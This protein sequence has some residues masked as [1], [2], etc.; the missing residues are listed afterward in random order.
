HKE[1]LAYVIFTSGSTGRPKG[2]AVE[3]RQIVNYLNAITEKLDLPARSSFAMV[4]TIAADL[5]NTVLFPAL[6][7][8]G[9]LHLI[10]EERSSDPNG[11]AEYFRR[12]QIDC[13]K[14]VPS[15]LSAMLSAANPKDI[16]PRRR[17]VLGG[18]GCPWSLA[19]T[20]ARLSPEC[21]VFNHY[22][23]TEATVGA[24]TYRVSGDTSERVS[25]TAPLGGPLANVQTY[26]LDEA[27]RPVPVGATGELHIG[28]A[29]L[30]RG[31]INRACATAEKFIPNP[32]SASGERLYKTGDRARYLSDGR[33]EFLG[34]I[35]NQV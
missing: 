32:F 12:H 25:E 19:E 35:D 1:N 17:L 8:G 34:R 5:G 16:L 3:Q 18:E 31:Y 7:K 9:T 10:D 11:L 24:T 28:G 2:V 26:I 23:P 30:A 13:L 33:I 27:L 6:C 20:I 21:L 15:H 4:S 14:I 29:G 22:G